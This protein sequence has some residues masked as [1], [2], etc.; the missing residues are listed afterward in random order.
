MSRKMLQIF[1]SHSCT[2][3]HLGTVLGDDAKSLND[4]GIADGAM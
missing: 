2:I 1:R 3:V 4:H